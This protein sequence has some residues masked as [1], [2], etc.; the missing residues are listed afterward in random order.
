MKVEYVKEL[1][2]FILYLS[3]VQ[4]ETVYSS[5]FSQ[6]SSYCFLCGAGLWNSG[7]TP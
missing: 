4:I 6:H 5:V 1:F 2:N 7:M 3:F